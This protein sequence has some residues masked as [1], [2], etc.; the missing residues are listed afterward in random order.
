M[1]TNLKKNK[2]AD[3]ETANGAGQG[4]ASEHVFE[5]VGFYMT[6]ATEEGEEVQQDGSRSKLDLQYLEH[7]K[8]ALKLTTD[9]RKTRRSIKIDHPLTR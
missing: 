3:K 7:L 4:S 2:S 9:A 5:T 8:P 1:K 6:A